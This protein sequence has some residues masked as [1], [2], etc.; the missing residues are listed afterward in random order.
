MAGLKTAVSFSPSC[1]NALAWFEDLS[2]LRE[3]FIRLDVMMAET[4][5]GPKK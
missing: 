1:A 3:K 2:W 5:A 4:R